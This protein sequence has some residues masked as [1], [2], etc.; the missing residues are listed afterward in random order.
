MRQ[1]DNFGSISCL[2]NFAPFYLNVQVVGGGGGG[3]GVAKTHL[4][5]LTVLKE[6]SRNFVRV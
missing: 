1:F 2:H 4:L 3:G 5:W 6:K